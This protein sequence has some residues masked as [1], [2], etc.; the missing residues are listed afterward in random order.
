MFESQPTC[1]KCG[2]AMVRRARG[3]DGAPFWGCSAYPRCRGTRELADDRRSAAQIGRPPSASARI[4][5]ARAGRFDPLALGLSAG[6]LLMGVGFVLAGLTVWPGSYQLLGAVAICFSAVLVAGSLFM[7]ANLAR[8]LSLRLVL[9]LLMVVVFA[10]ALAPAS[11][12]LGQYVSDS[13][14]RSIATH[15]PAVSIPT[16]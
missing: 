1:P 3:R 9:V 16:R 12:W 4:D 2:L 7:P 10:V 15:S 11:K 13:M 6:G 8:R 5:P 14:L